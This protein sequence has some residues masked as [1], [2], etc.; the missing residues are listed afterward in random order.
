MSVCRI[1]YLYCDGENCPLQAEAFYH[2]VGPK[3][4]AADQ[5]RRARV[6]GWRRVNG[7]DLCPACYRELTTTTKG[8]P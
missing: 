2:G 6:E 4:S 5:R 1:T 8:T 7:R 3:D